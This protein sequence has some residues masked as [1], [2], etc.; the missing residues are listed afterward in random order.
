MSYKNDLV[1]TYKGTIKD[2]K[3]TVVKWSITKENTKS[4]LIYSFKDIISYGHR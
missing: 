1:L 3:N 4:E 2:F